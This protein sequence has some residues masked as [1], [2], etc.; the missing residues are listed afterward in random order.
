MVPHPIKGKSNMRPERIEIEDGLVMRWS[1]K[2]DANNIAELLAEAFRVGRTG[3]FL[4][5]TAI[6]LNMTESAD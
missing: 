1:I 3:P 4:Q 5:N 2:E 6:P